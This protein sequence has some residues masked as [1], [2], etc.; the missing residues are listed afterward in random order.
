MQ[1]RSLGIYPVKSHRNLLSV[2]GALAVAAMLKWT[3]LSA[4]AIP[5][6]ADEAVVGLMARHI[7]QGE[8]PLFFYGQAYMGSLDAWLVAG[9][10]AGIGE[11]VLAI[12]LI[13]ILLYLVYLGSL[14][15]MAHRF[16]EREAIANMAIWIAA[17]PTVLMTTYTTATLG[18]YGELLVLGNFIL[19]L[20][21]EVIYGK[22]QTSHLAWGILGLSSGLAFWTLGLSVVY[23]LPLLVVGARHFNRR[24]LSNYLSAALGF[25]IGSSPWWM[26]NLTHN[27]AAFGALIGASIPELPATTLGQRLVGLLLLG[28][29]TL[30]GF[31]FPWSG[32]LAPWPEVFSMVVIYLGTATYLFWGIRRASLR[33]ASGSQALLGGLALS[34]LLLFLG[35]RFGVDATGRYFTPLNLPLVLA[36]AA[37]ADAAWQRRRSLGV[38]V[39]LMILSINLLETARAATSPDKITTQFDPISRFDNRHDAELM[40]FLRQNRETRGYSNYWVSFRL[41][42]LSQEELIFAALL[43]Y[44]AN[45]SYTPVDSRYPP[46]EQLVAE[47]PRVAYITTRQPE[48]DAQIRQRLARLGVAFS[49]AQVGDYHIFYHLSRIVRPVEIGFGMRFP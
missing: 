17:I 36:L 27:G 6:N 21:Y 18:G 3:L 32:Q 47:S 10:F 5:F 26:F 11:N 44:K 29:P 31:R 34:F 46:Y 23:L 40:T 15:M 14:W 9:A 2:L 41:A 8:R 42:F 12:R 19:W 25:L 43:P 39:L 49:E 30:L 45:L 16:F 48:V 13:Q 38:G 24:R 7:L 28:I 37:F 33:M 1:R 4:E 22:R 20:G 35:S